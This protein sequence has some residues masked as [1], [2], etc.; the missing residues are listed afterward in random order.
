MADTVSEPRQPSKTKKPR[1]QW[2]ERE[3]WALIKLWEDNLDDLRSHKHNGEVYCRIAEALNS[4]DVP[5]TYKGPKNCV[6][7]NKL[8]YFWELNRFLSCLPMNDST[9]IE[10]SG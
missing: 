6:E 4:A 10:E 9:L 7:H 5:K 2:P 3:T 1:V 8:P